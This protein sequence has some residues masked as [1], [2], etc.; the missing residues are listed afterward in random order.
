MVKNWS[1]AKK[2]KSVRKK[3]QPKMGGARAKSA[4]PIFVSYILEYTFDFFGFGQIFDYFF[5]ILFWRIIQN[6]GKKL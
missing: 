1:K 6:I 2:I 3:V 4:P 5:G